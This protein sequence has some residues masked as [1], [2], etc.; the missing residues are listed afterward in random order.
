MVERGWGLTKSYEPLKVTGGRPASLKITLHSLCMAP[1]YI[2]V[3]NIWGDKVCCSLLY[4]LLCTTLWKCTTSVLLHN[5]TLLTGLLLIY[6]NPYF[7]LGERFLQIFVVLLPETKTNIK[8]IWQT[9]VA[10]FYKAFVTAT[11][12]ATHFIASMNGCMPKTINFYCWVS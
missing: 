12:F 2:Q 10:W 5:C 4:K 8:T 6:R 11:H 1:L 7:T 9:R 3:H